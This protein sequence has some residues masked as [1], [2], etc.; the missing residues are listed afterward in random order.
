[1]DFNKLF[2]FLIELQ[3]NNN[4]DWF[5]NNETRYRELWKDFNNYVESLIDK[6]SKF[7]PSV[8]G[9]TAKESIF[10]IYKDVRFSKDKLPYKNHFA[11]YISKGGKKAGN[12]GY[13]IHIEPDASML[14]GGNYRPQSPELKQIRTAIFSHYPEYK[15]IVEN[16]IF[17]S[18]FGKVQ[19]ERLKMAP[20]G[21][22]KNWEFI[23]AIKLKDYIIKQNLSNEELVSENFEIEMLSSFKE[24][25]RFN[26]F[27]NRSLVR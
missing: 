17:V 5:K 4:R 27:I 26:E 23:D 19:G 11:A 24:M 1:M 22:D 3:F 10:R 25:K 20:K 21:F 2:H 8:K 12:A 6:I 16:E 7:D 13:Y 9:V 18:K 14:V 15:K